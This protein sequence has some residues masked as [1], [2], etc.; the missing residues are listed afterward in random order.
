MKFIRNLF[1]LTAILCVITG[2]LLQFTGYALVHPYV[3]YILLF[4]ILITGFTYYLTQLGYKNDPDNFQAYYFASMGFRMLMSLG[5]VGIYAWFFEEGRMAFVL[6]FFVLYFVYT[7][8]EIYSI[9]ANF[10][11]QLKKHNEV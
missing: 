11:P 7:G 9:L 4:F 1:F 6:N 5:V 8:F 10:A 2:A 3:W